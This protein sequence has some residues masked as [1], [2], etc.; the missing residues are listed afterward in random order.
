[1]VV[2]G[3][4]INHDYLEQLVPKIEAEIQKKIIFTTT[5]A[6]QGEGFVVFEKE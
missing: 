3:P 2:E 5:S 6:H 4:N 1:V